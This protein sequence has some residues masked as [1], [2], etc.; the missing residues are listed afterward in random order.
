M[1]FPG[2]L[3][4]RDQALAIQGLAQ[5]FDH[6]ITSAKNMCKEHAKPDQYKLLGAT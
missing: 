2:S 4:T 1:I 5:F 3:T 6:F